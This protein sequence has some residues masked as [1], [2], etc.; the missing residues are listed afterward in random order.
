MASQC[1][2]RLPWNHKSHL[3]IDHRWLVVCK[4]WNGQNGQ[5]GQKNSIA[6]ATSDG[7]NC[8]PWQLDSHVFASPGNVLRRPDVRSQDEARPSCFQWKVWWA[9]PNPGPPN[10]PMLSAIVWNTIAL[11]ALFQQFIFGHP[12][13]ETNIMGPRQL[14]ILNC[15]M[16]QGWASCIPTSPHLISSKPHLFCNRPLRCFADGLEKEVF[17]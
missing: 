16:W 3:K 10:P 11:L 17:L 5:N 14:K 12:N 6:I 8:P 7:L 13:Q 2:L 9:N 1:Y 4:K 15:L